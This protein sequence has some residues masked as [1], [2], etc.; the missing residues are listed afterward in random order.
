[1]ARLGILVPSSNTTAEPL[2]YAMV[3]GLGAVTAH[4]TRFALPPSLE[5]AVTIEPL[6]AGAA[7]LRDAAVDAVAF[8]GTSGSWT[9]A[10]GDRA[11]S[12]AL[13]ERTGAP[14]TTATL[15]TLDALR[16]LGAQRVALVFP[17]PRSIAEQIAAAYAAEGIGIASVGAGELPDN[18]TVGAMAP[19]AVRALLEAAIAPDTDVVAAIGTNFPAAPHAAELE[20]R[21]GVSLVDSGAATTWRLLALAGVA[22]PLPDRW[23]ALS[24]TS[25][26]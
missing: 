5:D 26:Q 10:A 17:G 16:A 12:D 3:H 14:A 4:F 11:L 8:H 7:L 24:R 18:P 23:G 15:A 19:E 20:Q 21:H 9:G 13:T 1:M 22:A 25:S 6:A 2:T